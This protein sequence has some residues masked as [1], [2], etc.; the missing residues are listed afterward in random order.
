MKLRIRVNEVRLRLS[1]DEVAQ[2]AAGGPI[3]EATR[4]SGGALGYRLAFGGDELSACFSPAAGIE[5]K[6]PRARAARWAAGGEV[7][8]QGTV[9]TG[10]GTL[11]VLIEKDLKRDRD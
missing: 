1:E 5:I 9:D 10:G 3:V 4:F 11:T 2:V 6:L 7:S 8:L